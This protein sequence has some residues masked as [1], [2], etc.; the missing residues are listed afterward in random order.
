MKIYVILLLMLMLAGCGKPDD[1]ESARP[2]SDPQPEVASAKAQPSETNDIDNAY[3]KGVV[4]RTNGTT[5][6][7]HIFLQCPGYL[8]VCFKI[9]S[10]EPGSSELV[11]FE[12]V[13][14][15][16]LEKAWTNLPPL[17]RELHL[18]EIM[19]IYTTEQS[20]AGDVLKAAPEE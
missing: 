20:P 12:E 11:R 10:A 7:G 17:W 8:T 13:Q 1:S 14:K 3:A 19:T 4:T 6:A 16:T 15:V 18:Q 5:V 2:S 9:N